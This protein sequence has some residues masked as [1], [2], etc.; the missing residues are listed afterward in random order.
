MPAWCSGGCCFCRE[1]L[2]AFP[3]Y[4][5]ALG[6]GC[7]LPHT[8]L[9]QPTALFPQIS[10]QVFRGLYFKELTSVQKFDFQTHRAPDRQGQS[11][12]QRPD[13]QKDLESGK[14]Q[15][16]SDIPASALAA[17]LPYAPP[18]TQWHQPLGC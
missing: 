13:I 3:S 2:R 4:E 5:P 14:K 7:L 18:S 1:D 9:P 16:F 12:C 11:A 6:P 15:I 10:P 17:I 8:C